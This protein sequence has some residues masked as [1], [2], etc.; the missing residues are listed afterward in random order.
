M[1]N[2][3]V[4]THNVMLMYLVEQFDRNNSRVKD[5]VEFGSDLYSGDPLY[6][7]SAHLPADGAFFLLLKEG[8]I[9]GRAA[10][11]FNA[12]I[13]VEGRNT[14]LLGW[15]ECTDDSDG[16]SRLLEAVER[17]CVERD[18]QFLVGPIN[19]DTWHSYRFALPSDHPPFFLDL[20]H[21]PWYP[22]QFERGGWVPIEHYHSSQ[23]LPTAAEKS[24]VGRLTHHFELKGI[25]IR[26]LSRERFDEE[27]IDIH[28][29]S[30]EA[31]QKNPLYT[32]IPF[33]E[34]ATLYEPLRQI[35]DPAFVLIAESAEFG[36]VGFVFAVRNLYAPE[37]SSLIIKTVAAKPIPVARGIGTLLVEMIHERAKDRGYRHVIH[38]LM[39]D[40]NLSTHVLGEQSEVIRRYLL[41]GK[42]LEG[43]A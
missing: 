17:H 3:T 31:F 38:A 27:L 24:R 7:P 32:P 40:A 14:A 18:A 23:I 30:L 22:S 8:R 9:C 35:V 25:S 13:A 2:S 41:F 36:I 11:T 1:G 43:S 10:V 5:F 28:K 15:Y 12:H 16:S 19:G 20:Y 34:M 29:L 37:N 42:E 21:K 4:N 6:R 26:E 39:H 33:Q